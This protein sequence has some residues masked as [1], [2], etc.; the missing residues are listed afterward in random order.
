MVTKNTSDT[1]AKWGK[2]THTKWVDRPG[3]VVCSSTGLGTRWSLHRWSDDGAT[4]LKLISGDGRRDDFRTLIV[5]DMG[6]TDSWDDA[7]R[8]ADL[9]VPEYG[10][11]RPFDVAL[12]AADAMADDY[13]GVGNPVDCDADGYTCDE[14]GAI[15]GRYAVNGSMLLEAIIRHRDSTPLRR[16]QIPSGN[17]CWSATDADGREWHAIWMPNDQNGWRVTLAVRGTDSERNQ[18]MAD[19]QA[20]KNPAPY[21]GLPV[22]DETATASDEY[23]F[24]TVASWLLSLA[25]AQC[26]AASKAVSA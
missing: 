21:D 2:A 16:I 23:E 5:H 19:W 17:P 7:L 13:F 3:S 22:W 15:S 1:R 18:S 20:G 4:T 10:K 9:L 26:D 14:I 12:A 8:L 11:P 25:I 6:S 24:V